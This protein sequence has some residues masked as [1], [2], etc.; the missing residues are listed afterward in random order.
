LSNLERRCVIAV[1]D[2]RRKETLE[3][4]FDS[5]SDEERQAISVVSI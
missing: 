3:Q 2:N 5:L 1:L 4:W